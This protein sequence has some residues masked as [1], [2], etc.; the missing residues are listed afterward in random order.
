METDPQVGTPLRSQR[1]PGNG[2]L[3]TILD[4][5]AGI[6]LDG[7]RKTVVDYICCMTDGSGGTTWS[8]AAR[9]RL[10]ADRLGARTEPVR[11]VLLF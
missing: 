3:R 10:I 4:Y 7:S 11:P 1:F 5:T 2:A 9:S 8:T 6:T